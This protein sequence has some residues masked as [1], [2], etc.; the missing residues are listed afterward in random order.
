MLSFMVKFLEGGWEFFL[1]FFTSLCGLH[2][3]AG[4]LQISLPTAEN[5]WWLV[6]PAA[7]KGAPFGDGGPGGGGGGPE[8]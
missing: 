8:K 6:L 2:A 3:D 5:T 7:Q 4:E 1:P